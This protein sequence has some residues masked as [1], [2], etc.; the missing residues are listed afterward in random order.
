MRDQREGELE[1]LNEDLD[2]QTLL[3][4]ATKP[5]PASGRGRGTGMPTGRLPDRGV[6]RPPMADEVQMARQYA[7]RMHQAR[8]VGLKR[9]DKRTPGGRFNARAHM[10]A[11]AQRTIGAPVTAHPWEIT[12]VVTAPLQ[13]P[14]VGLVI[15]TSGSMGAYEYA[16]GPIAWVL[17]T[18]LREFGGR[19]RDRPVRQRRR[20][21]HRRQRAAAARCPG[22]GPAAAPRSA[23]TRSACAP[24]TSS[25]TTLAGHDSSTASRTA[26][27]T[28]PRRAS[29]RS[30]SCASSACPPCTSASAVR[31]SSVEADRVVTIDDPADRDGHRR[32]RHR[33]RAPR[34]PPPALSPPAARQRRPHTLRKGA[35]ST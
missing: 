1:Q 4:A 20:A 22:S 31:P 23:A 27:G 16:L 17:S 11:H 29:R 12:K 7:R 32:R 3:K 28:T 2:L 35:S 24:S 15:D 18:G 6:D 33:R 8:E 26:D 30:A 10:R 19:L 14:H 13:E 34:P 5:E 21:A 9:I 25:S